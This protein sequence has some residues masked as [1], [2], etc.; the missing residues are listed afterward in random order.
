MT[1]QSRRWPRLMLCCTGIVAARCANSSQSK[2][3]ITA[4]RADRPQEL[5]VVHLHCWQH[6]HSLLR[7]ACAQLC[8]CCCCQALL[9]LLV[10]LL[11]CMCCVLA[12]TSGG[13]L[14]G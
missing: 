11:L 6:M 13:H 14:V 9:L 7:A 1:A 12:P 4:S 3:C 8:S 5:P 2:L 10:A